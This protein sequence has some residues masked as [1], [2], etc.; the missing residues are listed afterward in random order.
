MTG[1]RKKFI[2]RVLLLIITSYLIYTL[3]N[4][5]G[6]SLLLA[7]DV[8]GLR[9]LMEDNWLT[10]LFFTFLFMIIQNSVSIVPLVL[11][12]TLNVL[13]F[14]FAYG[15]FWSWVTSVIGCI[16][17][18]IVIRIWLQELFV[19][20]LNSTLKRK[21]EE[22][23]TLFIFLSRIIPVAPTS[24]INIVSAVSTISFKQY[25]IGTALGN[26]LYILVLSLIPLGIMSAEF[27]KYAFILIALIAIPLFLYRKK[28]KVLK[29]KTRLKGLE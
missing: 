3:L 18:F 27:E 22:N 12:V 28:L 13:F 20:K 29:T 21:L 4:F 25:V 1:V 24:I 8:D 15:Y 17:A 23:G 10:A 7:G 5:E 2:I 6:F 9:V 14:G 11:L 16:V 19:H 26:M